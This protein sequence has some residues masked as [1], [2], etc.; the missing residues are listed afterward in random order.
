M[1]QADTRTPPATGAQPHVYR[2]RTPLMKQGRIDTLLSQTEHLQVRI[3]CY[4]EGGENGLHAHTREDHTFIILQGRARFSGPDGEIA[5]LG[6]YEA[7][8]LPRGAFY[9]FE[10]CGDEPLVLLRV[11]ARTGHQDPIPRITPDGRPIPGD[12]LENKQVPPIVLEGA[13]FE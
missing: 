4:A 12:S 7:I 11:G 8:M 9:R 3:K 10:S 2:L 6:R 13:Y 1:A 5:T